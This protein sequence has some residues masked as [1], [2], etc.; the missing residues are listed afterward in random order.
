MSAPY[1]KAEGYDPINI[2]AFEALSVAGAATALTAATLAPADGTPAICAFVQCQVA[3]VRWRADGTDPT[4]AI[5]T[6]LEVGDEIAIWG[7]S[8]IDSIRF[9][10]RDGGTATLAVHYA[11]GWN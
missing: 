3:A 1:D 7:K 9:I 10:S 4:A 2:F 5:G 8:D 6:N 11:R